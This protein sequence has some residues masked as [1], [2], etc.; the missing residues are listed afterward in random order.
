MLSFSKCDSKC[1]S[2]LKS[3]KVSLVF[4]PFITKKKRKKNLCCTRS[5]QICCGKQSFTNSLWHTVISNSLWHTVISNSL[6]LWIF[7]KKDVW[8]HFETS[9][10]R[11]YG[12]WPKLKFDIFLKI[13]VPGSTGIG[14][15]LRFDIFLKIHVPGSTEIGQ[16][17]G[18][19]F[20]WKFMYPTHGHSN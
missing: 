12:N 8:Y 7:E 17:W 5:F 1:F 16:K 3:W 14:Q 13:H 20:F 4:F 19:I 9:W 15:N 6:W 2:I 10:A 18:L 11:V